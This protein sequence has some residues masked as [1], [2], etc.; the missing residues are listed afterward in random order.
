LGCTLGQRL[1][2]LHPRLQ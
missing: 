2:E 1:A